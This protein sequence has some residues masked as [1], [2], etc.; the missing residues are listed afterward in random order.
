MN[1][2][3][4]VVTGFKTVGDT[5]QPIVQFMNG[6]E[7]PIEPH[8]WEVDGYKG[9]MRKQLPL[10]LAWACTIHK[11]QGSTLDSALIDIGTNTFECGQAYVALSRVKSL[12]ALYVHDFAPAAFK[13][14]PKV[15]AFYKRLVA[16]T[17]TSVAAATSVATSNA[18]SNAISA[19]SMS[20]NAIT[21]NGTQIG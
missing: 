8:E 1:G 5:V 20:T 14:N 21:T 2:S 17:V 6:M 18:T 9:I 3:R 12:E 10:L 16:A 4:G 15:D 13:T 7:I 11:A 19:E